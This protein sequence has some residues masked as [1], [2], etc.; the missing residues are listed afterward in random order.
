MKEKLSNANYSLHNVKYNYTTHVR[1]YAAEKKI[2][3]L[4]YKKISNKSVLRCGVGL[5]K[6]TELLH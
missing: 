6:S 2:T 5:T 1:M 3:H 4:L